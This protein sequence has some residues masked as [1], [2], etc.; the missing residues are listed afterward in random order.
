MERCIFGYHAWY[1]R[2]SCGCHQSH[3]GIISF[4]T[5]GMGQKQD[6]C[7]TFDVCDLHATAWIRGGRRETAEEFL[8]IMEEQVVLR[9]KIWKGDRSTQVS[10]CHCFCANTVSGMRRNLT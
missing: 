7:Q 3:H 5:A 2:F 8:A 10:F 6:T 9:G 4:V 1:R